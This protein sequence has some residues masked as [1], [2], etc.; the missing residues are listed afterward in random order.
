MGE[1]GERMIF[2][3]VDPESVPEILFA[4]SVRVENYKNRFRCEKDFLEIAVNEGGKTVFRFDDGSVSYSEVG[5][6][7]LVLQDFS[8]RT[9]TENNETNR[10]TTVG[11]RMKYRHERMDSENM[12]LPSL[13]ER[14]KNN[15]TILLPFHYPL[16]EFA[17]P[18]SE[19]I[20]L[21]AHRFGTGNPADSIGALA[22]WY[23]M[24]A[25]ITAFTLGQIAGKEISPAA[26]RYLA[27]AQR[28]ISAHFSENP[29]VSDIARNVGISEGYLHHLFQA[30]MGCG[31][32]EYINRCRVE[33]VKQYVRGRGISL[34]E[35]ALQ[36]G[37]DDPA[38][39]SR[40]FRK[41]TGI[42]FRQ[43]CRSVRSEEEN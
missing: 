18:F 2:Y 3:A 31:V 40:L 27:Q 7:S 23:E 43:F 39:M 30:G 10:H 26:Q 19:R 32:T 17:R 9:H 14:V 16:G 35:A 25:Q 6:I 11:V 22:A 1:G 13:R 36:V 20:R 5:N 33:A 41:V 24:A 34:R 37:I 15:R 4:C 29:S 12:D 42:G 21:I 8:C 28:Y 38:Y